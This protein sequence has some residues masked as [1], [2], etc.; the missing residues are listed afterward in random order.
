MPPAPYNSLTR[1][2]GWF[3]SLL[4][5]RPL[6]GAP[7]STVI[8]PVTA[9]APLRVPFSVFEELLNLSDRPETP[10]TIHTEYR[11]T[12][13]LDED[14]LRTAL[15]AAVALHPMMRARRVARRAGLRSPQWEIGEVNLDRV[16]RSVSCADD[17][18]LASIRDAFY[19][20]LIDLDTAPA[21]RVLIA[22]RPGGDSLLLSLNHTMTDGVG[23]L[24]FVYSFARAY[25]GSPDPVSPID[26]LEARALKV[27]FG[28]ET[29]P[30]T[31]KAGRPKNPWRTPSFVSR[32][33]APGERGY[34][35]LHVALANEQRRDLDTQRYGANA[36]MNDLLQAALTLTIDEWN[37]A[38]GEPA[39]VIGVLMPVNFRP[40]AWYGEVVGNLTL[41]GRVMTT[42]RQRATPETLMTAVMNRTQWLKNSGGGL[43]LFFR[44][45]PLL[46][47]MIPVVLAGLGRVLGDRGF[48]GVLSYYG[49]MDSYLP[50]FGA[51]AGAIT[52]A[53]GSPPVYMPTAIAIG[54]GTLRGRLLVTFRFCR[55][56]FSAAAARR[57]SDLMIQN[58]LMLG[59][60]G[61]RSSVG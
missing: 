61:V 30:Q 6:R 11:F 18:T 20:E 10:S 39:N 44:L 56:A 2:D 29:S 21:L 58:L 36:T 24:R 35:F 54:S 46:Y 22:R 49:R 59:A 38:H 14:R 52:E 25:T 5:S 33:S 9:V 47:N 3:I 57:F 15:A 12:G 27:E 37:R 50:D 16:V 7:V 4:E 53:W 55:A 28:R 8:T 40:F 45:P 34:R 1:V 23:A 42:P 60:P 32:Q 31:L 43:P 19:S 17:A 26:A 48:S 13:V 51:E 41:G